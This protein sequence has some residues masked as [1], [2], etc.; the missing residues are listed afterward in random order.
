[1]LSV[2]ALI[3]LLD[4]PVHHW[5]HTENINLFEYSIRGMME[6]WV[7]RKFLSFFLFDDQIEE[8]FLNLISKLQKYFSKV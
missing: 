5:N 2:Y 6:V 3:I 7:D 8:I 4:L 1:M